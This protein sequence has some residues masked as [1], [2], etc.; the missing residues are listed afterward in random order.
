ME[1]MR[2]REPPETEFSP[3]Q[4]A[5]IGRMVRLQLDTFGYSTVEFANL[6]HP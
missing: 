5:V 6:L 4:P 3:E 2:A 1:R